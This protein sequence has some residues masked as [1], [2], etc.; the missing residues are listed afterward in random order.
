M[1]LPFTVK[2]FDIKD[3]FL[4][5][6]DDIGIYDKGVM[7]VTLSLFFI[8]EMSLIVLIFFAGFALVD[9]RLLRILLTKY[10]NRRIVSRFILLQVFFLFLCKP[11]LLGTLGINLPGI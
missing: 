3:V 10:I 2:V 5:F 7:G 8:L 9:E 4:F 11:V 1:P 6:L